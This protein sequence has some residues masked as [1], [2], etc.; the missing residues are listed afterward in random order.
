MEPFFTFQ[1]NQLD[2]TDYQGKIISKGNFKVVPKEGTLDLIITE[3]ES[4]GITRQFRYQI[5]E[6]RGVEFLLLA[7]N[8]GAKTRP[9]EMKTTLGSAIEI[10][11]YRRADPTKKTE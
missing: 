8:A 1:G 4:K 5:K 9:P 7:F 11:H 2:V 6:E 10:F 3:G